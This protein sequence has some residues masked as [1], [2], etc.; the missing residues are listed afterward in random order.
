MKS[1]EDLQGLLDRL[2]TERDDLVVR[3]HL[4]RLEA[5]AEWQELEAKLDEMRGKAAQVAGVAGEA[6]Q[7]I[8]AAARLLGEEIGR[9]Y[10]R[11]R[12]LFE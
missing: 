5:E 1:R 3:A 4:A 12:K 6:G 9:G 2:A 11:L 7:D 8:A 10:A